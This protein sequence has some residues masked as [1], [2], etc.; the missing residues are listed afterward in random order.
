MK[1]SLGA[2]LVVP[3]RAHISCRWTW[4]RFARDAEGAQGIGRR[5]IIIYLPLCLLTAV[6]TDVGTTLLKAGLSVV[7]SVRPHLSQNSRTGL[8]YRRACIHYSAC[9]C[10]CMSGWHSRYSF[11]GQ[12]RQLPEQ[13]RFY[14]Q[15]LQALRPLALRVDGPPMGPLLGA[16]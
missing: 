15:N 3:C 12:K 4:R 13:F 9:I 10:K 1:A 14:Q 11:P 16:F 7:C 6:G 5:Q 2:F 8:V